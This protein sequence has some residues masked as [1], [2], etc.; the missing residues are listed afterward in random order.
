M[1]EMCECYEP[2]EMWCVF[3]LIIQ[4]FVILNLPLHVVSAQYKNK[5]C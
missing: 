4:L 1:S 2:K 5:Y 3:H